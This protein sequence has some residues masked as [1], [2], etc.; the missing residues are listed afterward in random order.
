M[1][2]YIDTLFLTG[3]IPVTNVIMYFTDISTVIPYG[4]DFPQDL[5]DIYFRSGG[6]EFVSIDFIIITILEHCLSPRL[7]RHLLKYAK[8]VLEYMMIDPVPLENVDCELDQHCISALLTNGKFTENYYDRNWRAWK[9]SKNKIEDYGF[10]RRTLVS[11]I[12]EMYIK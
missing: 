10:V 5:L 4:Y 1:D 7:F 8:Y 2:E 6:I 11:E 9:N 12:A 3:R